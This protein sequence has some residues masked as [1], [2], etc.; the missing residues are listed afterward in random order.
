MTRRWQAWRGNNVFLCSGKIMLG[1]DIGPLIGTVTIICVTFS[2]WLSQVGPKLSWPVVVVGVPIWLLSLWFL[3][4]T[5]TTEPGIIPRMPS[6]PL[7]QVQDNLM[8]SRGKGIYETR[9]CSKFEA[10]GDFADSPF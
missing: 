7:Q 9:F 2:C 8:Q 4:L 10:F 3:Y 1:P 6:P 5:A